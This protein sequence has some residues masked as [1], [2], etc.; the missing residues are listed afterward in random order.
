M[1]KNSKVYEFKYEGEF[2]AIDAL[3][4]LY[5]QISFISIIDEIKKQTVPDAKLEIKLQ[6]LEKGSL[7]VQQVIE[8][9]TPAG[10]FL[11]DNY[12][13]IKKIFTIF[14]DL[15]KIK[16][17]LGSKK[18]TEAVKTNNGISITVEGNNNN[19]IISPE[20][21]QLFQDNAKI[22][23]A[24]NNAGKTLLDN[25]EVDQIV[26]RPISS[27]KP[28][29]RLIREDFPKMKQE[30]AYAT[31]NFTYENEF[32]QTLGIKKANLLPEPGRVLKW[33]VMY[34]GQNVSVKISDQNFVDEIIRGKRFG[35]GDKLL[36]D[37][38]K[39]MRLDK[40]YNMYVETGHYEAIKVHKL[41][42]RDEQSSFDL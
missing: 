35:N 34:R 2:H 13:S 38:K 10:L 6:G 27:K 1:S 25:R 11:V 7:E 20:A 23:S 40:T 12:S 41:I 30:S 14:S 36:V 22:N 32:N 26:V 3:T 16:S 29:S 19:I 37:L 28:I 4:V 15:F 9:I 42:Q 39:T 8:L 31:G 21:W 17:F 18:A 33:D 24:I 5:T